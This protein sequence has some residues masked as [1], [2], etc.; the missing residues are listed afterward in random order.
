MMHSFGLRAILC[1][2]AAL[3]AFSCDTASPD[4]A[5]DASAL[6]G[7]LTPRGRPLVSI[8]PK[9]SKALQALSRDIVTRASG[10][11][12]ASKSPRAHLYSSLV[13]EIVQS[14]GL[15]RYQLSRLLSD[16]VRPQSTACQGT[17]CARVF[18]LK[19]TEVETF[20]D[21]TY[22]QA[23]KN[24]R[25]ATPQH[26]DARA[27]LLASLGRLDDAKFNAEFERY[28]PQLTGDKNPTLG[29]CSVP[30]VAAYGAPAPGT[31]SSTSGPHRTIDYRHNRPK[32]FQGAT[33]ACHVYSMISMI[34]HSHHTDLQGIGT[35]D[36]HRTFLD[37]WAASLGGNLENAY[38]REHRFLRQL[39]E[40]R[41]AVVE[42]DIKAGIAPDMAHDRWRYRAG[43]HLLM[44]GQGGH[45]ITDFLRFR[46]WGG[47]M[48]D[49][50]IPPLSL[51]ELESLSLELGN[52]RL[53]VVDALMESDLTENEID[54]ILRKPLEKIFHLAKDNQRFRRPLKDDLGHYTMDKVLFD[55]DHREES[56]KKFF[57]SLETYGALGISRN[58]HATTV[59]AFDKDK[60]VF[61]VADSADRF[62]KDYTPISETALFGSLKAYYVLKQTSSPDN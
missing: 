23:I 49:S 22:D 44:Y 27:Y 4:H 62:A 18:G 38:D 30:A 41:K 7:V 54:V 34:D 35:I 56:A 47:V 20:L 42:K 17:S 33:G 13:G 12:A 57:K 21:Q 19:E 61:Y 8:A 14:R 32:P 48:Q 52:A 43:R 15:P 9:P 2:L 25:L 59:V 60:K 1:C 55:Q 40:H 31:P 5:A 50:S 58:N 11:S 28:V 45:A 39:A 3:A 6:T 26:A 53:D 29:T 10:R 36:P 37:Y 46:L 51:G 16:L 24:P